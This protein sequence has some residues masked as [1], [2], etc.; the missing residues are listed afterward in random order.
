[1]IKKAVKYLLSFSL[2]VLFFWLAF[3]D[4]TVE[5]FKRLLKTI[6]GV[7][8]TLIIAVV[9]AIVVSNILRAWRWGLLLSTVKEKMSLLHLYNST[10]IGYAVNMILPRVG[11]ISKAVNLSKYEK[12]DVKKVL[13]SVVIERILD[14]L[15]FAMLLA[16][17][18]FAFRHKINAVFGDIDFLGIRMPLEMMSY[19]MLL[20][21]ILLL[22]FFAALS[23]YPQQIATMIEKRVSKISTKAASKASEIVKSFIEGSGA[24]KQP[25][26]YFEIII[27][28]FVIWFIY[29]LGTL[30]PMFA[31]GFDKHYGLGFMEAMATMSISAFGQF[32]TP[33]GAG[34]YQY[35]CQTILSDLFGV[36]LPEASAFALLTFAISLFTSGVFGILSIIWQSYFSLSEKKAIKNT[37]QTTVNNIIL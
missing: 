21:T 26:K 36:L 32:V 12:I 14:T 35:I 11:E 25:A 22:I 28:S 2:A 15:V 17:S 24:L 3:K 23:L 27:S 8:L 10:M 13:A 18:S 16:I 7:D 33:A 1:M 37:N 9:I 4:F 5:D 29:L 20:M 19:L 30:L 6:S 34:T 31:M